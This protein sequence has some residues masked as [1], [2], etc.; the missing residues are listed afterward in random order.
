MRNIVVKALVARCSGRCPP[1]S[2]VADLSPSER[3]AIFSGTAKRL[4]NGAFAQ[5]RTP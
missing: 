4:Y 2:A 1:P 3:D 5:K